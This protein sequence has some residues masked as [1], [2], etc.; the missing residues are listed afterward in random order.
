M[1]TL[2]KP[3][4]QAD[5]AGSNPV[6]TANKNNMKTKESII[7]YITSIIENSEVA[8]GQMPTNDE[9]LSMCSDIICQFDTD[10]AIQVMDK[11]K[12]SF[13]KDAEDQSIEIKQRY[14]Y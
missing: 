10:I 1:V 4:K 13:G 9:F 6:L 14:G 2:S 11:L 3:N 5:I 12:R 7:N 8:N